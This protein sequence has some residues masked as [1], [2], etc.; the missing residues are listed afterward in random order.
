MSGGDGSVATMIRTLAFEKYRSLADVTV[1]LHPLT[2][3]TGAN[4]SGKSTLYR[5]M[6]LMTDIIRDGALTSLAW[7]GGM[8]NALHAGRRRTGP[9]ALRLGVAVDELNYAIELGLPQLSPFPLDPE[10]KVET[11]W[12]GTHPRPSTILAQRRNQAVSLRSDTGSLD[13]SGWRPR[14]EE[15]MIATLTD[16][17]V[18]PELYALR[19]QARSWQFYDALRVDLHAPARQPS[20]ATFSPC[21]TPDGGNFAAALATVLRVGEADALHTAVSRAFPQAT[22]TVEEDDRG[23]AHLRWS[24]GLTRALDASEISDGT[25]RFL[26]LAVILLSPRPP[27]FLVLNE[28]EGSIHPSLLPAVADLILVGSRSTQILVVSHATALVDAPGDDAHHIHLSHN[29]HDTHIEGQD[30]FGG[31]SWV[32]PTRG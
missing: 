20:P 12:H 5:G 8:R 13:V 28:P 24:T 1:D 9:V 25:L 4:G 26:M 22:V 10:V 14:I 27:K 2:V 18:S 19:E 23:Y 17:T 7:E 30:R 11:L 32:W 29:G 21:L 31:T 3:V 15:S 16:P 6:R